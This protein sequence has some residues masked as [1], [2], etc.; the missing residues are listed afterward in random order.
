M[1]TFFSFGSGYSL[2]ELKNV[3]NKIKQKKEESKNKA[4]AAKQNIDKLDLELRKLKELV[5]NEKNL[6]DGLNKAKNNKQLA[7]LDQ[8]IQKMQGTQQGGLRCD[9]EF[10]E[11]PQNNEVNESVFKLF[12]GHEMR[13]K[14][15][16]FKTPFYAVHKTTDAY[17]CKFRANADRFLEVL[18]GG[19]GKYTNPSPTVTASCNSAESLEEHVKN[20]RKTI[21]KICCSVKHMPEID[22]IGDELMADASQLVY[23]LT[24][25]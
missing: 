25:K 12:F 22:A 1:N 21:Y 24:F 17:L 7:K 8:E 2:D 14:L 16:H 23:L 4:N 20:F 15:E 3:S 10:V 13:I 11:P 9:E 6:T 19:V 18:Q 5:S